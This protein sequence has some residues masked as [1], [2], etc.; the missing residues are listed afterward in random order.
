MP[1][2][3]CLTTAVFRP[4]GTEPVQ[5]SDKTSTGV[6]FGLLFFFESKRA[7]IHITN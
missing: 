1:S 3:P 6:N 5:F 4:E 2:Q 7:F